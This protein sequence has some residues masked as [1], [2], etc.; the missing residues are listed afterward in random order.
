MGLCIRGG[1]RVWSIRWTFETCLG[2]GH[3]ARLVLDLGNMSLLEVFRISSMIS[4][5]TLMDSSI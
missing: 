4:H 1:L 2:D 3:W 5:T